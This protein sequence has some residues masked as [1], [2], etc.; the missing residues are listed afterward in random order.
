MTS[1]RFFEQA[2]CVTIAKLLSLR[3]RVFQPSSPDKPGNIV[4][5]QRYRPV[6]Q[7]YYTAQTPHRSVGFCGDLVCD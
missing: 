1:L 6:C 2:T 7:E 5:I 4:T 3:N